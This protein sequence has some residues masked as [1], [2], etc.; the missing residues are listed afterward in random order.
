MARTLIACRRTGATPAARSRLPPAP[1][2]PGWQPFRLGRLVAPE[3]R[4]QRPVD[5]RGPPAAQPLDQGLDQGRWLHGQ[6]DGLGVGGGRLL[7]LALALVLGRPLL[8]PRLAP[9]TQPLLDGLLP[10]PRVL[11]LGQL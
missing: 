5:R 6:R 10:R 8:D 11:L 7:A 9:L 1:C 4:A 2:G 3:Q